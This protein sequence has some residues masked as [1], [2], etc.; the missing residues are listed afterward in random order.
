MYELWFALPCIDYVRVG[1][2]D[3][4]YTA[5]NEQHSKQ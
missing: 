5:Y 3:D 2:N 1:G 4:Q